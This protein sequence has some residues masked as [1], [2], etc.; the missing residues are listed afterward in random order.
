MFLI[1]SL[2]AADIVQPAGIARWVV[3]VS[4]F[5]FA[6]AYVSTWGVVGKIYASE[7]Q[8]AKTR[9]A[10]NSI[11]TGLGFFT[12]WL[13]AFATP[14]L[15]AKSA[16]GAYFLF[17]GLALATLA[18]LWVYAPETKGQGLED[19]QEVFKNLPSVSERLSTVRRMLA[20]V[21]RGEQAQLPGI[22]AQEVSSPGQ[23][24]GPDEIELADVGGLLRP[25]AV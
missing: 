4:I 6:L 21:M 9:A 24:T 25:I 13:V 15:L 11:A 1:G 14:I 18:V 20:G 8:P 2:Y 19:I 23:H 17:G 5:I 7:I 3:V 16:Y 10:A 22:L 12:N